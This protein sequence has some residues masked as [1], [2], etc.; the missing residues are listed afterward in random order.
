M[1]YYSIL[2]KK[3]AKNELANADDS[4]NYYQEIFFYAILGGLELSFNI[5]LEVP[6][7]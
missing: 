7:L 3:E 6:I 2:A 1:L 5:L 4:T